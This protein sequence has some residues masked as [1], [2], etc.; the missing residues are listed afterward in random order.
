VA[1]TT[2]YG[3]PLLSLEPTSSTVT[4]GGTVLITVGA[5]GTTN[6]YAFQFDISFVPGVLAAQAVSQGTFLGETAAFVPGRIDNSTGTIQMTI[7]TRV[8]QVPG[9]SGDGPLAEISFRA[10]APGPSPL[11]LSHVTLLDSQLQ[12]IIAPGTGAS[13][14]VVPEP[15]AVALLAVGMAGLA[16][17]SRSCRK[18]RNA[19]K[20]RYTV[21]RQ[22]SIRS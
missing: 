13:I 10:L 18:R 19:V 12:E 20:P 9:V 15:A 14:T 16:T 21:I 17:W 2:G 4:P 7:G 22:Y 1:L 11:T 5:T 8:G 3:A 6:L